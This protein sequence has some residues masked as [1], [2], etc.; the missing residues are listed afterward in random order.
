MSEEKNLKVG[1][2]PMPTGDAGSMQILGAA[3][4]EWDGLVT[5]RDELSPQKQ[6]AWVRLYEGGH[7]FLVQQTAQGLQDVPATGKF[8]QLVKDF[9]GRKPVVSAASAGPEQV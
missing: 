3:K 4:L 5:Y 7:V 8:A 9:L 6:T 1:T 2:T